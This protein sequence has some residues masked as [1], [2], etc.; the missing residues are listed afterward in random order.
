[1]SLG[2]L[3]L[4][5]SDKKRL[6]G[7]VVLFVTAT[8]LGILMCELGAYIYDHKI[9]APH[10]WVP[11]TIAYFIPSPE[12]T[13]GIEDTSRFTT[14]SL[15]FRGREIQDTNSLRILCIGGSTTE[16][17][18]LDD[19]EAWPYLLE[20]KLSALTPNLWVGNAGVSGMSTEGAVSLLEEYI[21]R[22]PD[23]DIIICLSG[24][25]DLAK[26]LITHS[27]DYHGFSS[28]LRFFWGLQ[29]ALNNVSL[30]RLL[31][32]FFGRYDDR[33]DSRLQ[34]ILTYELY[35]EK[36][37]RRRNASIIIDQLPDLQ[38][39]L[40]RYRNAL[41][42][43]AE[44]ASKSDIRVVFLTQPTLWKEDNSQ[45]E[46]NLMYFGETR[47]ANSYYSVDVLHRGIKLYNSTL[48][49]FCREQGYAYIDLAK[50][51]P[52]DTTVFYDDCHFT[53]AGAEK[54]A[55]IISHYFLDKNLVSDHIDPDRLYL[56]ALTKE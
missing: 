14:N 39:D 41:Q 52:Q 25:N 51:I 38:D 40:R 43:F 3:V 28:K 15:G 34:N 23:L 5:S 16:C 33:K 42:S 1:L 37:K 11:Y 19:T 56:Q 4:F 2:L 36:R 24:I 48:I 21:K 45:Y 27:K 26:Q 9:K 55:E 50:E 35:N 8:G 47:S 17:F 12:A 20:K 10:K 53:E 6:M 46:K 54:I 7:N 18:T 44:I 22:V 31:D 49:N 30:Y 13:P 29:D 32:E